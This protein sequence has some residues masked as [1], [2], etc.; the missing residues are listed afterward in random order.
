MTCAGHVKSG[1]N[2]ISVLCC[3]LCWG[4]EFSAAVLSTHLL[5]LCMSLAADKGVQQGDGSLHQHAGLQQDHMLHMLA[6]GPRQRLVGTHTPHA[7]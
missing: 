3:N 2:H 4:T 1:D 6:E 5:D 7:G